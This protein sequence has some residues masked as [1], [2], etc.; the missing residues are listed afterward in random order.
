VPTASDI[1]TT[2]KTAGILGR[3]E[4]GDTIVYTFSE[5][6]DPNSILAGWTGT[7]TAVTLRVNQAAASDTVTIFDSP[8]TTLLP[9][10]TVTLGGTGFTT[11]TRNFTGST[12]VLSGAT[13]TI[14][15][16]TG[17][18]A[19]TTQG[20]NSAM[21]WAPVVTPTDLAGNSCALTV[22]N[23]GGTGDIDF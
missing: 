1:Q 19:T 17:S 11:T 14:T 6:I 7:S 4:I 9:F 13:V 23:E 16:G 10:G 20:A 12:M 18:G 15:L 21:V 2:N 3:A 5:A 8:N 22:A